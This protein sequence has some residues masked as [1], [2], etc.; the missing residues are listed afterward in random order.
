MVV[1]V[2]CPNSAPSA[3]R[4]PVGARLPAVFTYPAASAGLGSMAWV[5]AVRSVDTTNLAGTAPPD[6]AI[7]TVTVDCGPSIGYS[8]MTCSLDSETGVPL[9]VSYTCPTLSWTP[10]CG[11]VGWL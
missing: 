6:H 1:T 11:C 10:Y 4:L 3:Q 7:Y 9:N 2:T 5:S 8:N